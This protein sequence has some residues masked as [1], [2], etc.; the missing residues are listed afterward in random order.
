MS[1][2]FQ[3][4]DKLPENPYPERSHLLLEGIVDFVAADF[5]SAGSGNYVALKAIKLSDFIKL[6]D[7]K[8]GFDPESLDVKV[9][10]CQT[11]T[12]GG[13]INDY[14]RPLPYNGDIFTSVA[15]PSTQ[16]GKITFEINNQYVSS[17]GGSWASYL[18]I[19]CLAN[20]NPSSSFRMSAAYKVYNTIYRFTN[21]V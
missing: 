21:Y 4:T 16:T 19:I 12:T 11:T 9:W 17:G 5:S 10:M 13:D 15:S 6:G 3:S 8:K 18:Y 2:I 20:Y 1:D 14:I 7:R